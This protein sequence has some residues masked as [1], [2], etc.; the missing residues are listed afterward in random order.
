MSIVFS[1]TED[2]RAANPATASGAGFAATPLFCTRSRASTG[3][4]RASFACS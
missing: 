3:A 4:C 2:L 1:V